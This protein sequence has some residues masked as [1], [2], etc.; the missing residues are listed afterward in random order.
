MYLKLDSKGTPQCHPQQWGRE[1]C[2]TLRLFIVFYTS[3]FL[4]RALTSLSN[5]QRNRRNRVCFE[6]LVDGQGF[7]LGTPPLWAFLRVT[8]V[9]SWKRGENASW[10]LEQTDLRYVGCLRKISGCWIH[11]VK[12]SSYCSYRFIE[13]LYRKY[14]TFWG[15]SLYELTK[16]SWDPSPHPP[17]AQ[18]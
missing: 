17:F 1:K 12:W 2:G 3:Q 11:L 14:L 18:S 5:C 13:R 8:Q 9:R 7:L 15:E 10:T 16:I 4:L 6:I